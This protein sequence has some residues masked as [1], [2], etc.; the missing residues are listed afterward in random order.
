MGNLNYLKI[1][2]DN[3]G[4]NDKASWFLNYIIV[5]DLQTKEKFYFLCYDWLA[6]EYGDGLIERDIFVSLE[7]GKTKLKYLMKKQAKTYLNDNHLWLS[8]FKKPIQ[9]SF[10]RLDRVTCCFV[11]HY[12]TMAL[13]ILYYNSSSGFLPNLIQ[14]SIGFFNCTVEQV[15]LFLLI[16]NCI[17]CSDLNGFFYT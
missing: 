5:I 2:H 14:I 13:N 4:K 17:L 10:T 12:I 16:L 1:W 9:S 3:S 6:L 8:V 7:K 15:I 11:F